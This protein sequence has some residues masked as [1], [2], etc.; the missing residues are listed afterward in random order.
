[1][2]FSKATS[3]SP[4]KVI[5]GVEPLSPLDLTPHP[6]D[7]RANVDASKRVQEIQ[8]FHEKIKS[9][10]EQVNASYQFQA[11]KHRR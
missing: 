9:K 3:L 7:Q 10:I 8:E 2:G 11:N 5:Y 6:T 4:F 1:L